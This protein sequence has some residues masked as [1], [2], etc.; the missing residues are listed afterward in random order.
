MTKQK[1]INK[2]V[3]KN[4]YIRIEKIELDIVNKKAT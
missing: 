1:N 2:V 3:Y 4:K